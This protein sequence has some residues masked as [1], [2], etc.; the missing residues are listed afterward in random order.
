MRVVRGSFASN[1]TNQ[2]VEITVDGKAQTKKTDENGRVQLTGLKPGTKVRAVT[3][4]DADT[5]EKPE[6][7]RPRQ[8]VGQE[9]EADDTCE[10]QPSSRDECR[11]RGERYV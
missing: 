9:R 8:E 4:V 5:R 3:V 2:P 7:H 1:L 11:Q 10:D 6:E